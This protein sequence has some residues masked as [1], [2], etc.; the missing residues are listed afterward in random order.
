MGEERTAA[1]NVGRIAG[2]LERGGQL[3]GGSS[4]TK[5]GE[6]IVK[7]GRSHGLVESD[8]DRFVPEVTQVHARLPRGPE[9]GLGPLCRP[10]PERVEEVLVDHL[11]ARCL[12]TTGEGRRL[13]ADAPGDAREPLRPVVHRVHSRHDGQQHLCRAD[14]G[15][16]PLAPDMLF[17]RLEGHP[18]RRLSVHVDRDPDNPSGKPPLERFPAGDVGGVWSAVAHRDTESLRVP[19]GHV[20]AEFSRRSEHDER[21]EVRGHDHVAVCGAGGLAKVPVVVYAAVRC[22]ILHERPEDGLV[23]GEVPAGPHPN[24]DAQGFRA[25]PHDRNR[26]RVT[27]LGHEED[28]SPALPSL[29]EEHGHGLG[30]R[31]SLVQERRVGDLHSGQVDDRRLEVEKR[32]QPTLCDLGLIGSVLGVPARILE[33][34]PLDHAGG[35]RSGIPHPQVASPD[36]VRRSD[37]ADLRKQLRFR[38]S[39]WNTE[40]SLEPDGIRYGLSHELVETLATHD[41]EHFG[42]IARRGAQMPGGEVGRVINRGGHG[43]SDSGRTS[44]LSISRCALHSRHRPS[45]FPLPRDRRGAAGSSIPLR[46]GPY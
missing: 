1:H 4:G 19:N 40:R 9:N 30:S 16:G 13:L 22:R 2:G 29:A 3:G 45:G 33:D 27:V 43:L 10:H 6:E 44:G 21:Q 26:L 38:D 17:P 32:L 42:D 31:R 5:H 23:K 46:K 28:V 11:V 25:G 35:D 8:A 37:L 20:S 15:G 12:Q 41:F 7:V 14:V 24:Q 39:R 18:Q 34:V 36:V